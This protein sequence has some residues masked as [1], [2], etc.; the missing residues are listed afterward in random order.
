MLCND[1]TTIAEPTI[2][3]HQFFFVLH[4]FV[5]HL[6]NFNVVAN[7]ERLLF[8]LTYFLYCTIVFN[9]TITDIKIELAMYKFLLQLTPTIDPPPHI[10]VKI[11][12]LYVC[13]GI[14]YT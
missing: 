11:R 4:N 8:F 12:I 13:V 9:S 14:S 1:K 7:M 5:H 2:Q 3:N 6:K 10:L